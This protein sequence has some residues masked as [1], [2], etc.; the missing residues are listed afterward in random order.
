[1]QSEWVVIAI[2]STVVATVVAAIV[3]TIIVVAPPLEPSAVFSL[4]TSSQM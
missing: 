1:M 2:V 4:G 3:A